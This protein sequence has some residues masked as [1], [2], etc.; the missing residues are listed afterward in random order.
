MGTF[1]RFDL[2]V[3][4]CETCGAPLDAAKAGG[5]TACRYCGAEEEL[6]PREEAP[7]VV[8]PRLSEPERLES[9]RRQDSVESPI[10]AALAD[11]VAGDRLWPWMVPDALSRWQLARRVLGRAPNPTA[12]ED[13]SVLTR[14]LT[15]HY[16]RQGALLEARSL[17]EGALDRLR[18]PRHRQ[19]PR[20]FLA[21]AAAM[22]GDV[23]A[24]EAWL[25]GCD[26]SATDL[27]CDGAYRIARACID[28]ARGDFQS[29]LR[30][31]GNDVTDVPLPN[32]LDP[33]AALLRANAWE[34]LG[35]AD[36][37]S[38][39]LVH[40]AEHGGPVFRLKAEEV[41]ARH[42]ALRLCEQGFALANPRLDVLDE[43]RA[44]R[45]GFGSLRGVILVGVAILLG[46]F[47]VLAVSVAGDLYDLGFG[48]HPTTVLT[49]TFV[50]MG[51]FIAVLLGWAQGRRV[52]RARTL[53]RT[54]R[55]AQGVIVQRRATGSITMGVPE[56]SIRVLVLDG[57]TGY[58]ATT[59][60]FIR[61][62]DSPAF[63]R[64]TLV[65][66]RVDRGDRHTF[67]LV[68]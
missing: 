33:M 2:R 47:G 4:P 46:C 53:R 20:A 52:A 32:E 55:L 49:V 25:A 17:A 56:V 9:L 11:L 21:R 64:G 15:A 7:L 8:G 38:D 22:S 62:A 3:V 57:A 37:A 36:R 5:R 40:L 50:A 1:F 19:V 65:A 13:L 24:A 66:L 63:A 68:M 59:E 60:D 58:L 48:L 42:P 39:L 26:A 29:V 6:A 61:N 12:A 23:A 45:S 44:A 34:K 28:T 35:R 30:V 18:E 54:G 27:G 41:A 31:L 14:L 43:A 10:P 16:E 67:A 51:G